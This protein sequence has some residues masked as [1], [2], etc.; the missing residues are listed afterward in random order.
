MPSKKKILEIIIPYLEIFLIPDLAIADVMS[1]PFCLPLG[2]GAGESLGEDAVELLPL[3][4]L[5]APPGP[6][7]LISSYPLPLLA[8]ALSSPAPPL[9]VPPVMFNLEYLVLGGGTGC[10][11]FS[12]LCLKQGRFTEDLRGGR[13]GLV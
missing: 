9:P 11:L 2:E 8:T 12:S 1:I 3:S 10:L 6:L 4:G 5:V 7:H 13:T